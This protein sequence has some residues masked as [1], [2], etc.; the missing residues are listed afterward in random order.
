MTALLVTLLLA[1][2]PATESQTAEARSALAPFKKTLKDTLFKALET[3]PEAALEVC[4]RRAPELAK[5]AATP[6]VTVG[7]SAFKLRNPKNAAPAWLGPLMA[8]LSK[9][10][11]GTETHRTVT[12]PDGRLGYAEPIWMAAPCLVCHGKTIAPAL[13]AKL[14]AAYPQ[15]TARGFE[16]G[17]FRGVF[18]AE[19]RA[20]R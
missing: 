10:K 19:V 20:P 15:D 13:D 8:E 16:L 7:R 14:K 12:L 18:W 6:N 2:A 17:E 1:A 11:S 4:S 9:E 3:S 5:E